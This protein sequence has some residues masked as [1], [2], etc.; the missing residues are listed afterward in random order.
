V[1][2][3]AASKTLVLA[4]GKS[5]SVPL[6]AQGHL[7]PSFIQGPVSTHNDDATSSI[8]RG[9][10]CRLPYLAH[11]S[12]NTTPPTLPFAPFSTTSIHRARRS[13][14]RNMFSSAS[15]PLPRAPHGTAI[16]ANALCNQVPAKPP[17]PAIRLK[18]LG[19]LVLQRFR[20]HGILL[21]HSGS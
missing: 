17:S 8:S 15:P 20:Q 12:K 19:D 10:E 16:K 9:D 1:L 2:K 14:T 3:H 13:P 18:A 5:I 6:L 21:R 4:G 11:R 7:S